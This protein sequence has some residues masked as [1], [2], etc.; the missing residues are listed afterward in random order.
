[1]MSD[2]WSTS[3]FMALTGNREDTSDVAGGVLADYIEHRKCLRGVRFLV[4]DIR[5]PLKEFDLQESEHA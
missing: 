4:M 3:R 2:A 1:M 5:H